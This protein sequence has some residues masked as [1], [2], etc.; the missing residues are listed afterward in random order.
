MSKDTPEVGDVWAI[1]E[2]AKDDFYGD[3]FRIIALFTYQDELYSRLL[4]FEEY[5]DSYF[6]ETWLW[7]DILINDY[8]YLGKSKTNLN[9]LFKTENGEC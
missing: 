8:T 4:M 2:T 9:D 1:K 6:I 3:R 7:K 5:T